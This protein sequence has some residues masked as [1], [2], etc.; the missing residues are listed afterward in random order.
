MRRHV[1]LLR[2]DQRPARRNRRRRALFED[3]A[4][5]ATK[6]TLEFCEAVRDGG[7]AHRR[8]HEGSGESGLLEE[9]EVTI[10]HRENARSRI[11]IAASRW[12]MKE[13]LRDLR[14]DQL[15]K[16]NQNGMLLLL[17]AHL[18]SLGLMTDI[19]N[20]QI[21]QGKV[22]R[23]FRSPNAGLIAD[24]GSARRFCRWRDRAQVIRRGI[25]PCRR[26]RSKRSRK[27]LCEQRVGAGFGISRCGID[28]RLLRI[29]AAPRSCVA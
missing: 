23:R 22:P 15:R 5:R 12:S 9:G 14:G 10:Q 1:A 17:H 6:N 13:K 2:S 7:A 24:G 11:F 16:M 4:D 18:F 3:R 8:L 29:G 27:L 26:Y 25:V 21:Q 20:R 19:F 28:P